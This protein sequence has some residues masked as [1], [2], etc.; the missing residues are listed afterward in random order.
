[1]EDER[2]WWLNECP[3]EEKSSLFSQWP[4][5]GPAGDL[6]ALLAPAQE[7][8]AVVGDHTRGIAPAPT[9]GRML[10]GLDYHSYRPD[11]SIMGGIA[12]EVAWMKQEDRAIHKAALDGAASLHSSDATTVTVSQEDISVTEEMTAE[13]GA[14]RTTV[15]QL[16]PH[17][18]AV[19]AGMRWQKNMG[20]QERPSTQLVERT[21]MRNAFQR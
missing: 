9:Q 10:S 7:P 5:A 16:S 19:H 4:A 2:C 17:V 14:T 18:D 6:G 3:G 11:Q 12:L 15:L 21:P 8:V 1:M 20:T 13:I